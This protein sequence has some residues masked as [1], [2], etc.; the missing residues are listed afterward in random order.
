VDEVC[1]GWQTAGP[2]FRHDL[3]MYGT[4]QWP[5]TYLNV[6]NSSRHFLSMWHQESGARVFERTFGTSKPRMRFVDHHLA[7]AISAYGYSGFDD[8]AIVIM[9]GRG[10]WEATSIWHGK[11]GR[12]EHVQTIPFPNSIGGFYS[13]FTEYLGFVPNSDEWKVMGLAP[14]GEAGVKL[15]AFID[16]ETNNGTH[17]RRADWSGSRNRGG[18]GRASRCRKQDRSASQEYCF[19]GAGVL[20]ARDDERGSGGAEENE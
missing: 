3:K 15:D 1:F 10:A 20:R 17:Q 5:A 18:T 9:D 7:H 13:A 6:L 16:A 4:G 12:I 14:Y 8:A 11:N 19:R 2:V